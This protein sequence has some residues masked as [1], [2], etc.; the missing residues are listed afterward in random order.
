MNLPAHGTTSPDP[1]TTS[2]LKRNSH[3]SILRCHCLERPKRRQVKPTQTAWRNTFV[4]RH[5]VSSEPLL[6]VFCLADH[7]SSLGTNRFKDFLGG[8]T[9]W[10]TSA[11]C[12]T[13]HQ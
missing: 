8:S 2:L 4:A 12:L 5:Q 7:N 3:K 9:A 11:G 13:P 1:S 10:Q 6:E